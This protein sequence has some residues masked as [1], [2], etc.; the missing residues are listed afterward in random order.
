M[1][2][3]SMTPTFWDAQSRSKEIQIMQDANLKGASVGEKVQRILDT[4]M[5]KSTLG[6]IPKD[7]ILK[8]PR[9]PTLSSKAIN[10]GEITE[11]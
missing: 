11:K 8:L 1:P 4:K 10:Y 5:T 7:N 3:I 6:A 2:A 9:L